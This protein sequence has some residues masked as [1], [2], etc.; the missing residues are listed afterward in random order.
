M[1]RPSHPSW[2]DCTWRRVQ[3]M[4][5]LIMQFFPNLLSL[6]PSLVQILSCSQTPSVYVPPLM[7][8]R[9]V[10]RAPRISVRLTISSRGLLGLIFYVETVNS[11]LYV[12][13]SRSTF[14]PHL[15]A[16]AD[17]VVHVGWSQAAHSECCFGLSAW[18]FTLA[19]HLKPISSLFS[20]WTELVPE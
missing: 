4:K 17:S 9:K 8:E 6:H 3:V 20:M 1:P 11:E 5:L 12:T 18:H 2:L 14:A 16:V 13:M 7:S 19:C 10:H 15:L